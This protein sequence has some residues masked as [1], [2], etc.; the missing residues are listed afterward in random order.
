MN[1]NK[2]WYLYNYRLQLKFKQKLLFVF[3]F[4]KIFIF[5]GRNRSIKGLTKHGNPRKR[6]LPRKKDE[7]ETKRQRNKNK[8]DIQ[9]PCND[10]CKRK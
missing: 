8:H 7:V 4:L 2:S 5:L 10:T 1:R 9:P 6:G 3:L